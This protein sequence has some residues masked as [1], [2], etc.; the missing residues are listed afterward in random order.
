MACLEQVLRNLE[1]AR[2]L[3]AKFVD[4]TGGEPLLFEALPMALRRAKQ[5]G[6]ITSVTTN[7]LLLAERAPELSGLIDLPRVSLDGTEAI[8]DR[9]RGRACY[10][11]AIEGLEACRR[12]KIKADV[13]FTLCDQ[14]KGEIDRV[15][16]VAR[17]FG[18]ILIVDP[19]FNYFQNQDY[20]HLDD[21]LRPWLAQR[22][23]YVNRA[24]LRLR[25]KRGNSR[26]AP[27]CHAVDAV[28][29]IDPGN[30]LVLPCFHRQRARVPLEMGLEAA[31]RGREAAEM[32]K[33]QG[34]LPQCEGCAIHCY[35]DPSFCYRLDAY[36]ALSL[37]SKAK[38]A[39]DKY[40]R[41]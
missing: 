32:R 13:L 9:L 21:Q 4:F 3:G 7:G 2:R 30:A 18:A 12:Y 22:G 19:V 23:V 29:V 40:F 34:R 28:I 27:V 6:F 14:N 33:G 26:A 15:Y 10:A 5:L 17:S 31:W 39:L 36:F 11:R 37:F 16:E 35:M 25:Q 41:H 1:E 24:F 38:Y 8:H 20:R